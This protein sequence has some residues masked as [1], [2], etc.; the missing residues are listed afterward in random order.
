MIHAQGVA[1]K[2]VKVAWDI[3]PTAF[4]GSAHDVHG[5]QSRGNDGR[6]EEAAECIVAHVVMKDARVQD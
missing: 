1:E 5:D 3:V 4:A 6:L 2:A